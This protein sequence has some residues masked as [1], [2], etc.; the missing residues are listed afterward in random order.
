MKR[1]DLIIV[2]L[3]GDLGKP[4]PAVIV[5]TDKLD[6][7]D[8]ILVCPGTSFLREAA[9]FRRVLVAPDSINNLR[10]PTQ[11]QID[12]VIGVRRENCGSSIGR[13]DSATMEQIDAQLMLVLGLAE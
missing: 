13:L 6:P 4:R 5:E 1:G 12:R 3:Q 10:I 2:A 9:L 8:H 7:S 11:F